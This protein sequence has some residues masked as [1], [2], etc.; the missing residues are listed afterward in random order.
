ME[1]T[2]RRENI[3]ETI[4]SSSKPVS[5]TALAK[6][7]QVSRQ[8]IVGD[9]ALLRAAGHEIFATPRGYLIQPEKGMA[10]AARKMPAALT[11]EMYEEVKELALKTFHALHARCV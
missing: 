4:T 2:L 9:I 8:I 1:G 7:Y 5:A 11:K 6:Q 3:L 10:S